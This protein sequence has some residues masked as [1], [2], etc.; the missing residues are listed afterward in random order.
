M[1]EHRNYWHSQRATPTHT[2]RQDLQVYYISS[3][4]CGG[5]YEK[6][7]INCRWGEHGSGSILS[8]RFWSDGMGRVVMCCESWENTAQ[9]QYKGGRVELRPP[10]D[11]RSEW[12]Q[13][14]DPFASHSPRAPSWPLT[15]WKE[16]VHSERG[17]AVW[18]ERKVWKY[19]KG[20]L[21]WRWGSG[22][23]LLA[24]APKPCGDR[25]LDR[26]AGEQL[27][28]LPAS[29]IRCWPGSFCL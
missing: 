28:K 15:I 9:G 7:K 21:S 6:R 24:S 19:S 20:C 5:K 18:M 10:L 3:R 27:E 29:A 14:A 16:A 11:L 25:A 23:W 13:G 22:C 8:S 17:H 4:K 26:P 2:R 12:T 1:N